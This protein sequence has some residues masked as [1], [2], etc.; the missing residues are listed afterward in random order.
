MGP[1]GGA[2]GTAAAHFGCP[3]ELDA[4]LPLMPTPGLGGHRS[5]ASGEWAEQVNGCSG[6]GVSSAAAEEAGVDTVQCRKEWLASCLRRTR[7]IVSCSCK[8]LLK[9]AFSQIQIAE[10]FGH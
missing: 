9:L 10:D 6:S 5:F 3:L 2:N 7:R 4:D 8:Q 1:T